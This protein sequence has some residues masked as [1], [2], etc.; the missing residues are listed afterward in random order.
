M[1]ERT[2]KAKQLVAMMKATM[3]LDLDEL[4]QAGVIE[5]R[6]GQECSPWTKW[7]AD[8]PLFIIKL[9]DREL[10][11]LA[12][13]IAHKFPDA[14]AA[15]HTDLIALTERAERAEALA[16]KKENALKVAIGHIDHM[17]AWIGKNN[18]GYSFEALNEDIDGIRS[19][20]TTGP[21]YS[22]SA[23]IAYDMRMGLFPKRSSRE[24]YEA[25]AR[26]AKEQS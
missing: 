7:N 2:P 13:L 19:A 21:A 15:I 25:A 8:A 12:A 11:S 20:V 5:G 6:D 10:N 23:H 18:S 1:D 4:I 3:N 22:I 14:F 16:A 17:A 26:A 24:E 9:G